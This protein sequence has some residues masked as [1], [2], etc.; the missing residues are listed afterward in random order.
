MPRSPRSARLV[1]LVA[2]ALPLPTVQTLV[3]QSEMRSVTAANFPDDANHVALAC[4]TFVLLEHVPGHEKGP[5]RES[6]LAALNVLAFALGR[7]GELSRGLRVGAVETLFKAR[8]PQKAADL[9]PAFGRV[10]HGLLVRSAEHADTSPAD[11]TCLNALA[12]VVHT[13][14]FGSAQSAFPKR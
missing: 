5:R 11:V 6:R 14:Y 12:S 4:A 8:S 13:K 10:L 7:E 1:E 2:F 3:A 9:L